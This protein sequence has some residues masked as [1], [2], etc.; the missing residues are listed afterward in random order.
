MSV[1]H[2]SFRAFAAL[3]LLV[4][5]ILGGAID[6]AACEPELQASSFVDVHAAEQ[7][8]DTQDQG[9]A[10]DDGACVHGHCHHGAQSLAKYD[11]V[12]SVLFIAEVPTAVDQTNLVPV[13]GSTP[14]RPP[15][16]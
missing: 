3:L 12:P 11:L 15:R 4:A 14:K 13:V 1:L 8:Q 16:A 9:T 10:D 6:A 2:S 7:D 5:V